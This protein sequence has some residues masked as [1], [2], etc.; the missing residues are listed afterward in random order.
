MV[1]KNAL[2]I[3]GGNSYE[4]EISII[5]ALIIYN[6]SRKS[7]YNLIPVYIDRNNE[8]FFYEQNNI[9]IQMFKD[10]KQNYKKNGF[11]KIYFKLNQNAIFYKKRLKEVKIDID[12]CLNCCHG[13]EGENGDIISF[14]K[15]HNILVSSASSTALGVC[16]NKSLTKIFAKGLNIPTL[17]F[18]VLSKD[19]FEENSELIN[20]IALKIGYPIII[21]PLN[22]GS[23]IGIDIVNNEQALKEKLEIAF[24]F[25]N[26]VLIE[27]AIVQNMEEYNVACMLDNNQII[28]SQIDKPIRKGDILSFNDK[29]VGDC[30]NDNNCNNH[31]LKVGKFGSKAQY[32]SKKELGVGISSKIKR[33]IQFYSKKIYQKL[34]L[35]GVVR[36]DFIGQKEKIFLNE[37]NAVPG[38]LAYYFFVPYNFKNVSSYIDAILNQ[39]LKNKQQ[40]TNKEYITKLI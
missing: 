33:K 10:F 35:S 38:S 28:V 24:S 39:T 5:T 6:N 17:K 27:K 37:I 16:M 14:L 8:W 11:K 40:Q 2:I 22:L 31:S 30:K 9:K 13:G 32:L 18:D 20:D 4:H 21:K 3:F 36:I 25:D 23:S 15:L 1:K 7:V 19:M 34:G 26:Q 12:V 29:Y